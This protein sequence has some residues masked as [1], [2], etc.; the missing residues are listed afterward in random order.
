MAYQ[1]LYS[2]VPARVSMY[3]KIDGFDTFAQSSGIS[4]DFVLGEMSAVYADKMRGQDV[5]KLRRGEI[6]TVYTQAMLRPGLTVQSALTYIPLDYTGERSA[7]MAHS[8]VLTEQERSMLFANR[9]ALSFNPGMFYKDITPFRLT[10][11]NAMANGA[12]PEAVYQPLAM[13]DVKSIISK[14]HP[15]T[16][17]Y[18]ICAVVSSLCGIGNEVCFRLPVSDMEASDEALRL[19]NALMCIL[20]Y[21]MREMLSFV[22]FVPDYER[23]PG[24]RLKCLS[25]DAP[26]PPAGRA[27]FID[28]EKNQ[29]SG[30]ND[31][32]EYH[33]PLVTFLYSLFENQA[34]RDDFHLYVSTVL[35][36]YQDKMLSLATLG[37]LVFLFWQCSGYYSEET[38]LPTDDSVYQAFLIYE[39]YRYALSDDYRRRFYHCLDRYYREHRVIP[40]PIFA[41]AELLYPG[42]T[43]AAREALLEVVLKLIHTDVMRERLFG[44]IAANYSTEQEEVKTGIVDSLCRVFY[45]GF[46]RGPILSLFDAI[47]DSESEE[48]RALIFDKLLLSIRTPAV[49][50]GVVG[51]IDKHYDAISTTDRGRVYATFLEMLPECDQLSSMLISLVNKRVGRESEKL[52]QLLA[53]RTAAYLDADYAARSYRLLPLLIEHS[54]FIDEVTVRFIFT[55]RMN[56]EMYSHYLSILGAMSAIERAMRIVKMFKSMPDLAASVGEKLLLDLR[57]VECRLGITGLNELM[58]ADKYA[59]WLPDNLA[60]LFRE[61]IIYPQII[62]TFYDCFKLKY[63]KGGV[64]ALLKYCQDKTALTSSDQY[65]VVTNYTRMVESV[66]GEDVGGAFRMAFNIPEVADLHSDV[67]DYLEACVLNRQGHSIKSKFI[68]ELL[69]HYLR[70]GEIRFDELYFSYKKLIKNNLTVILDASATPEKLECNAAIDTATIVLDCAA[71]LCYIYEDYAPTLCSE[72]SGLGRAIEDLIDAYGLGVSR[73]LKKYTERGSYELREL[74]NDLIKERN[75][76]IDGVRGLF[77]LVNQSIRR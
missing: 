19:I 24:F 69:I 41:R 16:V 9:D 33:R 49:Q 37:E 23:Y 35:A 43:P 76:K 50:R 46:L 28:L 74:I 27:V 30:F 3:R 59:D 70:T 51:F 48:N 36:T 75:S 64:E 56:S 21:P 14:Y 8:L 61:I 52:R 10:D 47:F 4:R 7:Y 15:E 44:L 73:L 29:V 45:G 6:P 34:V 11:R 53:T 25:K 66:N 38:V 22:T 60:A 42:E 26:R 40:E 20:P 12:F 57:G 67:A 68:F 13:G 55:E 1:H 39:Q 71:E 72:E 17:K 58:R 31:N 5:V 54:G 63:G 65:R 32:I 62:N 18:L 2:C 77:D